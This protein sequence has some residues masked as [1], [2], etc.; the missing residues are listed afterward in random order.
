MKTK[1]KVATGGLTG[2]AAIAFGLY[3]AG[4]EVREGVAYKAYQDG[5]KV[6]TIC[7]GDTNDVQPGMVLN[8]EQCRERDERNARFAWDYVGIVVKEDITW[9]QY[10]AY[11]DYVFNAGAGNFSA[12][13]MLSWANKGEKQKSCDAFLNHMKAG[14]GKVDC[15]IRSNNC[16]GIVD[17]RQWERRVCL[18]PDDPPRVN[19]KCPWTG[20]IGGCGPVR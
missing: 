10:R 15:R 6:W 19:F 3:I 16:F 4:L 2:A 20:H 17:R 12:S 9:G 11:A 14:G 1:T 5:V 8:K 7:M 13:S 18:T